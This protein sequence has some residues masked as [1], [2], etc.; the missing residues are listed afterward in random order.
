M[1]KATQKSNITT[2]QQNKNLYFHNNPRRL[3]G[4]LQPAN[5]D[6]DKPKIKIK[7]DY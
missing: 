4:S 3:K 5:T 1:V 7:K 2:E 6:V